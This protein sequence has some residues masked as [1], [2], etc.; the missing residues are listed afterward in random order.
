MLTA[1]TTD[2]LDS[3][4]CSTGAPV[5]FHQYFHT[6]PKHPAVERTTMYI[7]NETA[8]NKHSR[9]CNSAHG[10]SYNIKAPLLLEEGNSTDDLIIR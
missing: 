4:N 1:R 8:R 7:A 6:V 5:N 2:S 9:D 10:S 3:R